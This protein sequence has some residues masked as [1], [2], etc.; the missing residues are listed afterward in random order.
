MAWST[1]QG[2]GG[3]N[4]RRFISSVRVSRAQACDYDFWNLQCSAALTDIDPNLH[5]DHLLRML[6]SSVKVLS[7]AT[8]KRRGNTMAE[9]LAKNWSIS[10]DSAKQTLEVATQ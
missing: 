2:G 7:A 3:A 9:R 1:T 4:N 5:E 8:R 6:K 10:V